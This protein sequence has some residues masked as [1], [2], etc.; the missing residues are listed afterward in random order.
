MKRSSF[1]K[2]IS[3]ILISIFIFSLTSCSVL[4]YLKEASKPVEPDTIKVYYNAMGGT[5]PRGTKTSYSYDKGEVIKSPP[6]P[7]KDGY[8]FDGWILDNGNEAL[9]PYTVKREVTFTATW[10]EIIDTVAITYKLN[11]GELPNGE[12]AIN[13]YDEGTKIASFPTPTKDNFKFLGWFLAEKPVEFP[14]VADN[15]AIIVAKWEQIEAE[16][17]TETESELDTETESETIEIGT[18]TQTK[19]ETEVETDTTTEIETDIDTNTETDTEISTDTETT[20][21]TDTDTEIATDTEATT[22]TDT[23]TEATTE[24]DTET[25]VIQKVTI[26]LD[27]NG[28]ALPEGI[29]DEFE[30]VVGEKLGS[31]LPTPTWLGYEFLG[32]YENGDLSYLVD[33]RTVVQDT[34]MSLVAYWEKIGEVIMVEFALLEDEILSIEPTYFEMIAGD[35]ALNYL[36]AMPIATKSGYKFLG[37][38]TESG[39][40][41]TLT[42]KLNED[43]LLFPIWEK[44]ILCT[45]GTENHQWGVWQPTS[46]A[47][48]TTPAQEIRTCTSCGVTDSH[49][50][51]P[52]TGHKLSAWSTIISSTGIVRMRSCINCDFEEKDPLNNITFESFNIPSVDGDCWGAEKSAN[53]IDGNYTNKDVCGKGTGT[54]TVTLTAKKSTYVDIFTVTG[55]GSASYY[56]TVYYNNGTYKDIGI[57]AFGS[58]DTATKAFTIGAFVTKIVVTMESPS[59][60]TDYWSELSAFVVPTNEE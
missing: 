23:D 57:G 45:D 34:D 48:C 29:A 13:L 16:I 40:A 17:G 24:T 38:Q 5:M 36:D 56:V 42:S 25:E 12:K 33:K 18:D 55:Y 35:R 14:F 27:T 11:G 9:F 31:A 32:W 39:E 53:L 60:G 59:N 21:N 7:T 22:T 54:V 46:E 58:E 4:D 28:G 41:V 6:Q 19:T 50:T 3:L 1:F 20:T 44:L 26:Y 51:A 30:A 43:T 52:S 47:T 49:I 2:I 8:V 37:W 15:N 10:E